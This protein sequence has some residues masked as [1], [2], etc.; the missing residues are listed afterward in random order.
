M[1]VLRAIASAGGFTDFAN[2]DKIELRR[3]NGEKYLIKWKKA[4]ENP[5]LDVPVY[6]GDQVTVH[7]RSP[8]GF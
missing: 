5:K 3:P 8:L 2:R 4:L 7:K 1:T 6:P